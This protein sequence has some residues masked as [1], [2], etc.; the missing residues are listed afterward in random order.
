MPAD[1]LSLAQAFGPRGTHEVA[2]QHLQHPTAHQPGDDG[3]L[4][5]GQ[6]NHRQHHVGHG[7]VVPA[8]DRQQTQIESEHQGQ[9]RGNHKTGQR[10]ARHGHGHDGVVH[11]AV[12]AQGRNDAA[13]AAQHDGQEHGAQTQ[14]QAHRQPHGNELGHVEVFVDDR[15]T[16]VA[17]QQ[18]LQI[19]PELKRHGLVQIVSRADVLQD[20]RLQLSVPIE[21]PAR[22][23]V[24]EKKRCHDDDQQRWNG[25]QQ[26]LCNVDQHG[27]SE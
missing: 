1:H 14:L 7:A 16:E 19:Q 22:R 18:A 24:H 11:P 27:A 8:R 12:L 21:R 17:A 15:G 13:Q 10:D 9:N 4:G 23:T 25:H 2:A 5:Q 3:H 6:S 20:L 26:T